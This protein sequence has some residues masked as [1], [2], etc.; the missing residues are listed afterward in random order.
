MVQIGFHPL[1]N[2]WNNIVWLRLL[3]DLHSTKQSKT[4]NI[5]LPSSPPKMQQADEAQVTEKRGAWK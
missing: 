5:K 2:E 4:E 3:Y 1:E